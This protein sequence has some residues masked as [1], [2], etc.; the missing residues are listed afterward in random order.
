M[1]GLW[2]AIASSAYPQLV[3]RDPSFRIAERVSPQRLP[4]CEQ[5]LNNE[6]G[7]RLR[8]QVAH[9]PAGLDPVGVGTPRRR[10]P[11]SSSY[12]HNFDKLSINRQSPRSQNDH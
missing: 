9:F 3:E 8:A 12:R 2:Q 10:G 4:P 7:W 1:R 6:A 5:W 11:H